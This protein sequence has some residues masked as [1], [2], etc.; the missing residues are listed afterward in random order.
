MSFIEIKNIIKKYG[1][2]DSTTVAL[3]DVSLSINK[4]EM[5]AIV[6][7]S[8]SGK[9]TLLNILGGLIKFDEGDYLFN[10]V[11]INNNKEK[12]LVRF[13]RDNISFIVQDFAL[14]NDMTVYNNIALPLEYKRLSKKEIKTKV[15]DVLE[16]LDIKNNAYKYANE[17]SGGQAQRVAIARAIVKNPELIL[18]DEPTGALDQKTGE[19]VINI[20]KELNNEGKTI[21]IVTHDLNIAEKCD[22]V[23]NLQDGKIIK[24]EK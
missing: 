12:E 6:G 20:L 18:A 19:A 15:F 9:S 10:N 21:I 11:K 5:I 2:G 3:N 4:G 17:I 13:R 14:I 23:I 8:G 1:K 7:K 16:K 22:R 24:S